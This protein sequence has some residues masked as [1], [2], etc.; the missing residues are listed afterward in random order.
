MDKP[1]YHPNPVN[2]K[3]I[4]QPDIDNQKTFVD[5]ATTMLSSQG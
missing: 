2:R 3:A 1:I 4:I 5:I